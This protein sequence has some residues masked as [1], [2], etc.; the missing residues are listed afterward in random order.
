MRL[1]TVVAAALIVVAAAQPASAN[2]ISGIPFQYRYSL[3][4]DHHIPVCLE[5]NFGGGPPWNLSTNGYHVSANL[6]IGRWNSLGGEL[7]FFRHNNTCSWFR[8]QPWTSQRLPYVSIGWADMGVIARYGRTYQRQGS[9]YSSGD[10]RCP[11]GNV[12]WHFLDVRLNSQA[13]EYHGKPWAFWGNPDDDDFLDANVVLTHELG[14]AVQCRHIDSG[15]PGYG[16]NM[17]ASEYPSGTGTTAA[18]GVV[19]RY[20]Y[21]DIYGTSH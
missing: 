13:D 9:L 15:E 4:Y 2:Q 18:L 10:L 14:H 17:M 7:F 6:A 20:C 19:D 12:C 11:D 5:E 3:G 8:S 16:Y 1:V 21:W